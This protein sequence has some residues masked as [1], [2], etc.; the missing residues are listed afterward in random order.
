M[1][2]WM[3]AFAR[4]LTAG[5]CLAVCSSLAMAAPLT[6]EQATE[7]LVRSQSANSKCKILNAQESTALDQL[8]A[9]AERSL[10]SKQSS[11]VADR[12]IAKGR[13]IGAAVS[14]DETT[15]KA[16][17]GVLRAAREASAAVAGSPE[18]AEAS[19]AASEQT[20]SSPALRGT[21]EET[22]TAA[23]TKPVVEPPPSVPEETSVPE[24]TTAPADTETTE[25]ELDR[26]IDTD[27]SVT[28]PV[29]GE[30]M[31][32]IKPAKAEVPPA[33]QRK[34]KKQAAAPAK[35][36]Q[37]TARKLTQP[38]GEKLQAYTALAQYYY[39]QRRCRIMSRA[40]ISNLYNRV[41]ATHRATLRSHSVDQVARA[42]RQAELRAN[43]AKCS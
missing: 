32:V 9:M 25:A 31:E 19:Q 22:Q 8:V 43:Q 42:M 39:L 7:L 12:A 2:D 41:V 23:V 35:K 3:A 1:R 18:P 20:E 5:V 30:D 16:V 33:V 37:E 13:K 6:A 14:C 11:T 10:L 26:N 38:P 27:I 34:P 4:G 21:V 28:K 40:S 29:P 15:S 24:Q 36:K 17:R